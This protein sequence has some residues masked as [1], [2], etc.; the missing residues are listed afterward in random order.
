MKRIAVDADELLLEE[1]RKV[2]DARTDAELVDK[3]LEEVARV[4]RLKRGIKALKETGDVFWMNYLEEIRPNSYAA[5][6][7]RRAS[8]EG[9]EPKVDAIGDRSR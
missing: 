8:Y 5:H 9:R 2:L 4:A 7:L 3:A 6:E 1:A